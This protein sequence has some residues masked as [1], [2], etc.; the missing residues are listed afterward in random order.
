[1]SQEAWFEMGVWEW[2]RDQKKQGRND[3][4][5]VDTTIASTKT[6]AGCRNR[7]IGW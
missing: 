5:G 3:P 6:S 2:L 7:R 4:E 1:M